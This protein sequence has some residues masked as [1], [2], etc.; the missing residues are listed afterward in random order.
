MSELIVFS[1]YV[2][3]VNGT[4]FLNSSLRVTW[5]SYEIQ[6]HLAI[7]KL[8]FKVPATIVLAKIIVIP[9]SNYFSFQFKLLIA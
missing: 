7:D 6:P 9:H 4:V 5:L 2:V 1:D 3:L 8:V